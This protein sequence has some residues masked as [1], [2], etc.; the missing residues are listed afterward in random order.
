MHKYKKIKTDE[1]KKKKKDFKT[2]Y[3]REGT[4][5]S[6]HRMKKRRVNGTASQCKNRRGKR[7][8]ATNFHAFKKEIRSKKEMPA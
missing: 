7:I 8:V 1:K 4:G 6:K 3:S 2:Q 5:S